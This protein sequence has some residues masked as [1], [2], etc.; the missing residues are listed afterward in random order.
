MNLS[1]RAKVILITVAILFLAIGANTLTSN[2]VFTKDYSDALQSK[3]FVIGQGLNLQLDR[4]LRLGIQIEDLVGFEKQC[5]DVVNKYEEISYAMVLDTRGEILFHN[6][7]SQHGEISTDSTSLKALESTKEVVQAYSRQGEEFYD[8]A[9][10][11]LNQYDERIATI[12]IGVPL[13]FI[14][15]KTGNLFA[16]SVGVALGSLGLATILLI[17]ALTIWVT[18][19]LRKLLTVIQKSREQGT[20]DLT[21]RVEIDSNDEIGQ[22]GSAFNQLMSDLE[23]SQEE[24]QKYT[25]ELELRVDERTAELKLLNEQLQRDVAERKRAEEAL[26]QQAQELARSNTELE[27]FAYVASHDLQEPLRMVRSYVQLL[28]RRYKGQLDKDADEFIAYAVDGATRMQTLI[29]DLLKYSRVGTQGKPVKPTDC[30]KVLQTVLANLQ[31]AIEENDAQMTHDDLPTVMADEVQLTQLFQ[32]L[33]SNAIKFHSDDPPKVHVGVEHR[34]G[35]WMFSVRDN[36][37]GI[38][39]QQTER[40]FMIFQRLHTREEYKGTGIGLA[41][42]KKIVGRHGGRIWVEAEPGKGSTFFFTI[43]DR[44]VV[45]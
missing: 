3:T 45:S 43:P 5:Q 13:K 32:N 39:S 42:C 6:D 20:K 14:T 44:G 30:A 27:Q 36:G 28:D 26:A 35:E 19:P 11:V 12:R 22:L 7:P 1:I 17:F 10:P 23:A 33:I 24:I 15:Q 21:G 18:K 29:N 9:I 31:M 34:S 37:I 2:Y 40:I 41:V 16:Y 8:I 25:Q 4:I 38:E